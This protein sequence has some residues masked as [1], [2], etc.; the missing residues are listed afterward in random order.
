MSQTAAMN[1]RN[2]QQD[3]ET[4]K[5]RDDAVEMAQRRRTKPYR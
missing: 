5:V 2:G 3:D 1:G 4:E